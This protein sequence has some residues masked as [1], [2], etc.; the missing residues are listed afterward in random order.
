MVCYTNVSREADGLCDD[1]NCEWVRNVRSWLAM[2]GLCVF[3]CFILR[4]SQ[5]G[6]CKTDFRGVSKLAVV[7][8]VE[9]GVR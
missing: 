9:R 3:V 6:L 1:G 8:A 4:G 2:F 5:M 7:R